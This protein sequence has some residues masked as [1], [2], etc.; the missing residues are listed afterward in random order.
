MADLDDFANSFSQL[1]SPSGG[2]NALLIGGVSAVVGAV[3][4]AGAVA[5]STSKGSAEAATVA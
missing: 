2:S 3:I 1:A 5:A 4:G